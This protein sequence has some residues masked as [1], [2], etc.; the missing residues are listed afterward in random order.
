MIT[1]AVCDDEPDMLSEITGYIIRYMEQASLA[2]QIKTFTDGQPLL[3]EPGWFDLY[4]LDI[5]MKHSN[6][7]D[8][9]KKLW[10]QG[11]RGKYIFITVLS[12]YVY[13][14]FTVSAADYFIKPIDAARFQQTMDR[15]LNSLLAAKDKRLIIQ[16][17]AWFRTIPY[18]DIYFCEAINRKIFVHTTQGI[19][20]YYYRLEKL[21]K[22][23]A[24]D[25]FRCHR[26][27]LVNLNHVDGY[28]NGMAELANG[29]TV[30]VSR[31]RQQDFLQA[32]LHHM[33]EDI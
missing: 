18:R 23:L 2:Y 21:E 24:G 10:K 27:Y 28:G 33:K 20:D 31:L 7:M 22:Q 11:K 9:A 8:I 17:E 29:E 14:A 16:K 12:D 4:F 3:E 30:P 1:I 26:S 19:I 15:V 13:D 25:F 32:V 5:Q 6:G